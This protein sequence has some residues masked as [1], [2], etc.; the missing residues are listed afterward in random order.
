MISQRRRSLSKYIISGN[1]EEVEKI[2]ASG[3]DLNLEDPTST[4]EI[5]PLHLATQQRDLKIVKLLIENKAQ[6][7]ILDK[8]NGTPLHDAA[9][10]SLEIA[11]FLIE[12]NADVNSRTIFKRTPVHIAAWYG[13]L[14]QLQLFI[15]CGG[16]VN[17]KDDQNRSPIDLAFTQKSNPALTVTWDY[18]E[19]LKC[20]IFHGARDCSSSCRDRCEIILQNTAETMSSQWP[21]SF[22]QMNDYF[23][24]KKIILTIF[25]ILNNHTIWL[26]IELKN[27]IIQNVIKIFIFCTTDFS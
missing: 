11:K 25:L 4:Q 9:G 3:I 8:Y 23:P 14:P 1:F 27:L 20:L 17:D 12:N 16:N 5:R 21:K 10:Y 22:S 24:Y 15:N 13:Q 2:V 7:N 26:P 18:K 6:V 19:I